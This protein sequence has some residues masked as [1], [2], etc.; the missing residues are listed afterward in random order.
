MSIESLLKDGVIGR[1]R[2]EITPSIVEFLSDFSI[3][4]LVLKISSNQ[5][6]K[7]L[8]VSQILQHTILFPP[9]YP[10]LPLAWSLVCWKVNTRSNR[11]LS[12]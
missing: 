2:F 4:D 5:K 1:Y 10:P 3:S 9:L 12:G 7:T 11:S 6:T 8:M